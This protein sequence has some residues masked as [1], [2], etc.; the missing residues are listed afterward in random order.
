MKPRKMWSLLQNNSIL[1]YSETVSNSVAGSFLH[2]A[3]MNIWK[4]KNPNRASI[5]SNSKSI[6]NKRIE[7]LPQLAF[8][9]Q[10][11]LGSFEKQAPGLEGPSL[12]VM[13]KY[14][15]TT[16]QANEIVNQADSRTSSLPREIFLVLS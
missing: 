13:S 8:R 6:K 15:V 9:A 1:V 11:V 16:E 12:R 2:K 14:T 3:L 10:K 4:E 5:Y 7:V